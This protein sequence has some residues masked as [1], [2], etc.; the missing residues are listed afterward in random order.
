MAIFYKAGIIQINAQGAQAH[1][2]LYHAFGAAGIM[3]GIAAVALLGCAQV[4]QRPVNSRLDLGLGLIAGQSLEG[5]AGD[6]GVALTGTALVGQ[7]PATVVK[8]PGKDLVH[9]HLPCG[10][11]LGV[12]VPGHI[13]ISCVQRDQRPNRAVDALP[14]G[15]VKVSQ[16]GEQ[17]I[18]CHIG[19]IGAD[20]GEG[21]DQAG[22]FGVLLVVE[23]TFV[24]LHIVLHRGVIIIPV[25]LG[26][27]VAGTGQAD[28]SPFAAHGSHLRLTNGV[29]HIL[30]AALYCGGQIRLR[31]KCGDT[32]AEQQHESQ[33]KACSA[34]ENCF[35]RNS[36]PCRGVLRP[37]TPF[38]ISSIL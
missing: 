5:H 13:I 10:L 14:N 36:F 12:L 11:G 20:G 7:V 21:H 31:R 4:I 26:Y 22:I 33:E 30:G 25:F 37:G 2:N 29:E 18:A 38:V 27:V 24:F 35:H 34:F 28:D 3:A 1:D 16:R 9:I 19:G 8:L 15:L 23:V 17:V 32:Q 6:V